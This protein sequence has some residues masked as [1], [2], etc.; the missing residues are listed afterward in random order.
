MRHLKR[1]PAE[2]EQFFV[3]VIKDFLITV[4]NQNKNERKA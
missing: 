3:A 2:R 4:R 1:A